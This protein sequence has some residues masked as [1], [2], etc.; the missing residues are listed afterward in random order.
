[1]LRQ[2]REEMSRKDMNARQRWSFLAS[3]HDQ[4]TVEINHRVVQP[5]AG[6]KRMQIVLVECHVESVHHWSM[7][8]G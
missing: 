2:G 3:V 4:L 7:A 1:M 5:L 8:R 6:S